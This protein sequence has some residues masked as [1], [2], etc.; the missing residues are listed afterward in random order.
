MPQGRVLIKQSPFDH[1]VLLHTKM[2]VVP[3][4]L[5]MSHVNEPRDLQHTDFVAPPVDHRVTGSFLTGCQVQS[6]FI[7]HHQFMQPCS[8]QKHFQFTPVFSD[9]NINNCTT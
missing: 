6:P 3:S 4:W 9:K 1:Q 2:T 5:L 8:R 7:T